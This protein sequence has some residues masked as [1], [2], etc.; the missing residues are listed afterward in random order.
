MSIKKAATF[1]IKMH[2]EK[3]HTYFQCCRIAAD[4]YS[5]SVDDVKSEISSR[6]YLHG[7][8]VLSDCCHLYDEP[9][10]NCYLF[11]GIVFEGSGSGLAI[12]QS[13]DCIVGVIAFS[14]SIARERI[15]RLISEARNTHFVKWFSSSD[16]KIVTEDHRLFLENYNKCYISNR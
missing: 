7:D 12:M 16:I 15:E 4:Y 9:G 13:Y 3:Q 10:D 6:N 1:A 2:R 14:F 5:V 11:S 8:M